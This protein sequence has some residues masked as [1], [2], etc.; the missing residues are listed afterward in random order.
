M[1]VKAELVNYLNDIKKYKELTPNN[2][3]F[4]GRTGM[5]VYFDMH[6]AI[7]SALATVK[8]FLKINGH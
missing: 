3:T 7:S 8:K 5:Y 4:I 6:M 1:H 2:V